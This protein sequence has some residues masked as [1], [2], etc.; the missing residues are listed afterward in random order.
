VY[1]WLSK[2]FAA[3]EHRSFRVLWI[4]GLG[5]FVAF[6]MAM[7]VQ[8]VGAF[9]ISGSNEAVGMVVAGQGFAMA[10]LGPI[11]GAFADR[12]PKRRVIAVAQG[13]TVVTFTGLAALVA[14][15]LITL[16]LLAAAAVLIGAT[17][18]FLAPARQGL[19]VDLVPFESRANAM[20]ITNVANT[21]ARVV[22][23]AVAG[24]LLAWEWSGPVGAYLC[25]AFLYASSALSLSLLP[26]SVVRSD[27]REQPIFADVAAGLGYVAGHPKLRLLVT[28]FVVVILAGFPH[29]TVLPGLVEHAFGRDASDVSVL[30]ATSAVGALSAS[31][32]VARFGD[33]PHAHVIYIACGLLFGVSLGGLSLAP[34]FLFVAVAMFFVGAGSGGFQALNAAVIAHHTEPAYIGRVMSLVIM[35]FAGFGLM[36]LP[37]GMLADRIG[38]RQTLVTMGAVVVG[39]CALFGSLL[40]RQ[41]WSEPTAVPADA[42]T[43]R[44]VDPPA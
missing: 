2:T 38:E 25:M 1:S 11:G 17:L 27:A 26:K 30:F 23:P 37:Y 28:L 29:V 22:G 14:T 35:A 4:G 10:A 34:S 9:R 20:A 31:L 21:G 39:L 16:P 36:S 8:S 15:G 43:V 24:A 33:S 18:A 44:S 6:F 13:V 32:V 19:A 3:L 7:I 41:D 40:S 12:W 5:S 42:A